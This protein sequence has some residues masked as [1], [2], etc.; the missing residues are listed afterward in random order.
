MIFVD[1]DVVVYNIIDGEWFIMV[2][3]VCQFY[4]VWWFDF[5]V[6]NMIFELIYYGFDLFNDL[7]IIIFKLCVVDD[8]GGVELFG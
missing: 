6:V 3:F 1:D 7:N 4:L 5:V 8:F 2:Y